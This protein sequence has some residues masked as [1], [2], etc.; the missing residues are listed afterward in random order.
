M[1]PA[2]LA[3]NNLALV[4]KISPC[5]HSRLDMRD[6]LNMLA[7][8]NIKINQLELLFLASYIEYHCLR[9]YQF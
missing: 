3:K 6:I 9:R 1:W 8:E 4:A 7:F 2:G 5:Y